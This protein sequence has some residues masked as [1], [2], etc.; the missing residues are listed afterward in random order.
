MDERLIENIKASAVF[1]DWKN[2][3]VSEIKDLNSVVG[4]DK[5]SNEAAGEEAKVRFKTV[6]KLKEILYP[7]IEGAPPKLNIEELKKKMERKFGL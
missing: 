2:Y 6:N 5:L 4:L 7:L 3:I 1:E